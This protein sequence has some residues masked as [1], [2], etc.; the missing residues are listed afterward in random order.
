MTMT[1]TSN[2]L[3]DLLYGCEKIAAYLG[4]TRRTAYHL[5]ESGKV[6]AFRI[7]RTVCARRGTMDKTLKRLEADPVA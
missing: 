7:G 4:V 5:I 1:D 6:P 2:P 3:P